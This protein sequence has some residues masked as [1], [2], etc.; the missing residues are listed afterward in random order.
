MQLSGVSSG[1]SCSCHIDSLSDAIAAVPI[2]SIVV[3][4][5]D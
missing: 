5:G 1:A 2:G 4:F 3:P